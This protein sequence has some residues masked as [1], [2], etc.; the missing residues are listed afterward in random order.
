MTTQLQK[1]RYRS[2]N[3]QR[4]EAE[5]LLFGLA[6]LVTLLFS[7]TV[8]LLSSIRD[9]KDARVMAQKELRYA[10]RNKGPFVARTDPAEYYAR[11]N[12]S[13]SSLLNVD[14]KCSV[15]PESYG[16]LLIELDPL[17]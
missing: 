10:Q 9:A 11:C 7:G 16:E 4:G 15:L 17:D 3:A 8:W 12:G 1:P 6:V 14:Y 13:L 5:F 2:K